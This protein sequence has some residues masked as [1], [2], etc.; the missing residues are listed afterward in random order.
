M[1]CVRV[2]GYLA[3]PTSGFVA[4]EWVG[5]FC[6]C[7]SEFIRFVCPLRKRSRLHHRGL[8]CGSAFEFQWV[9]LPWPIGNLL[10]PLLLSWAGLTLVCYP[11]LDRDTHTILPGL[12]VS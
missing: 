7:S 6:F 10:A 11:T 12:P 3:T 1:A 5:G 9:E 2:P 8:H 4:D